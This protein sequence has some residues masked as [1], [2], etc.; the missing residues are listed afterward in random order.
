MDINSLIG[1]FGFKE[2]LGSDIVFWILFI[3]LSFVFSLAIGKKRILVTIVGIYASF[4]VVSFIPKSFI[5][6]PFN[7]A[8]LFVALLVAFVVMFGK[9]INAS[10]IGSSPSYFIKSTIGSATLLGLFLVI[11]FGWLPGKELS[12]IVTPSTKVYFTDEIY[13]F[14][15]TVAPLVFLGVVRKKID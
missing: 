11:I 3:I 4:V 15:W 8:I 10:L 2:N 14:L 1:S 5:T 13:R 6:D 9:I 12:N 7:R